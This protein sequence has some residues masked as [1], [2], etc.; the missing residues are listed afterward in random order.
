MKKAFRFGYNRYTADNAFE[1]NLQYVR[2]NRDMIDEITL[3][4]EYSHHGYWPLEWQEKSCAVLKD[5]MNRYR[6]AGIKSVGI[7]VLATVGHIDE[8]FDVLPKPPMQVMVGDDGSVSR[9]CP[10]INSGEYTEYILRRYEMLAECGPDFIWVDDD[11]RIP[12]HGVANPCFCPKCVADFSEEYGHVFDR[13]SLVAAIAADEEVKKAFDAFRI[14]KFTAL[15]EK[16]E[17]AVHAANP[18][19]KIGF[20][21]SPEWREVIWLDKFKATM[22]RPGGGFY[23]DDYPADVIRK[24]FDVEK[25][26][27]L[28]PA[29][30]TDIQYEFENFPYQEFAKSQ[31]LI[32]TECAL[33]LTN[34]CNGIL[35]NAMFVYHYPRL[36]D[37]IRSCAKQWDILSDLCGK[38]TN[39]GIFGNERA[40]LFFAELGVPL[41]A[42]IKEASAFVLCGEDAR[43]LSDEEWLDLFKGG[44]LMDGDAFAE[45]EKRGFARYCGVA[46]DRVFDNGMSERLTDHD[47]TGGRGGYKRDIF[48]N[49]WYDHKKVYTYKTAEGC[50]VLSNLEDV[51]HTPQGPACTVFENELGGRVC[52]AGYFFPEFFRCREMQQLLLNVLDYLSGKLPAKAYGDG[53]VHLSCRDGETHTVLCAVNCSMDTGDIVVEAVGDYKRL[54]L[55]EKD[56]TTKELAAE[57]TESGVRLKLCGINAW[58]YIVVLCEK[59]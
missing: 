58:D 44:V 2:E 37:T 30:I 14:G 28:Y 13:E 35:Y 46:T 38:G 42:S 34:G 51:N 55:I 50:G 32:K 12:R 21:T 11:F 5:R 49:F 25:Q 18:S 41:A 36:M 57:P 40:C 24:A 43:K 53:R 4:V 26:I 8:S 56:G 31:T 22:G 33:A 7:N 59:R 52:V 16:I 54:L 15:A 17:R 10:C 9:S 19:V 6:K 39:R 1:E 23:K 27:A 20:M 45:A 47:L 29:Y 3:F 48:M